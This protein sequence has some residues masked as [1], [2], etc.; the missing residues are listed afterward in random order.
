MSSTLTA[1]HVD[2]VAEAVL[3][4]FSRMFYPSA[5]DTQYHGIPIIKNP[6]DLWVYQEII[7]ETKPDVIIETGTWQGGSAKFLADTMEAALYRGTVITIDVNKTAEKIQ[8]KRI[9]FITG[10][11]L[12]VGLPVIADARTMVILD[13]DHSE[14]H[15]YAE[16]ERFAPM[17]T[18]GCYLIVEDTNLR[19]T[20]DNPLLPGNPLAAVKRFLD[21]PLGK[22][23]E[24]DQTREKYMLTNNPGG[25]LRRIA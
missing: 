19:N 9:C 16:L 1:P 15:V 11:S 14:E 25:Y 22:K 6:L 17:V 4:A 13:S 3:H 20:I 18:P 7:W 5:W 2:P 10:D 21:T 23:F 24:V 12:V 8:D